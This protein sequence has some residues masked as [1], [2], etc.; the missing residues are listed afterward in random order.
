MVMATTI[1]FR[2]DFLRG[3][4]ANPNKIRMAYYRL[5]IVLVIK[6]SNDCRIMKRIAW[7][8]IVLAAG[9]CAVTVPA[10]GDDM[11][12]TNP[13]TPPPAITPADFAW[14]ASLIN[15]KEIRLGEAAQSNSQNTAVQDFGK[16][17]VRDHKKLFDR[18]V[19]ISNA[20]GLPLPDTNTFY[21][22]VS[23]PEEKPATELMPETPQQRLL[24]AQLA[25][26]SL[27][28]LTG[29][30]FDQGYASVMVTGH[31]AAVQKFEDSALLLQDKPLKKYADK[32]LR[33]IRHHLEMAQKL[34]SE[35]A[36]STNA[37]PASTHS[38]MGG[39]PGM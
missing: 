12:A 5:M 24:E 27:V 6:R 31:E 3:G 19:K 16:H 39:M 35:L 14:E 21:V 32:G 7:D 8:K 29:P 20:E 15:L 13:P 1:A 33:I 28:T 2:I 25:V 34:Q 37:P 18:L 38:T 36:P 4:T 17:M 9:L 30:A 26:Q 11:N 10:F 22:A 23:A